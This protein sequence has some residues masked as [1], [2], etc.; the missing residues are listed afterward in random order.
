[1]NAYSFLQ[2][3][4]IIEYQSSLNGISNISHGVIK[5]TSASG[6]FATTMAVYCQYLINISRGHYSIISF[7]S[8]VSICGLMKDS[9]QLDV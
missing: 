2:H 4:I 8:I 5:Q 1:M 9:L 7:I 6:K 3:Q